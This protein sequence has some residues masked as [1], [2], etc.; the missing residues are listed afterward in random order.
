MI[1]KTITLITKAMKPTLLITSFVLALLLSSCNNNTN[2]SFPN[3]VFI[4]IDDMGYGDIG[5][6]GSVTNKTPNL[7]RMAAAACMFTQFYVTW[8]TSR[9]L[10]HWPRDLMNISESLTPTT[11]G[12]II[13]GMIFRPYR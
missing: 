4:F 6:F 2:D 11:C 7:D 8:A 1:N 5:P 3:I 10:C 9:N 12:T 13:P